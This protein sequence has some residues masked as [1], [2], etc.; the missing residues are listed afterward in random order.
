MML[1]LFLHILLECILRLD[2]KIHTGLTL[3]N[4]ASNAA[5]KPMR[6]NAE[7]IHGAIS[8]EQLFLD[9]FVKC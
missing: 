1:A 6:D 9:C 2:M 4:R 7:K 3:H 5:E 8:I